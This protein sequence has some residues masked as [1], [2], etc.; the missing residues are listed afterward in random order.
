[1][2]SVKFGRSERSSQIT[3]LNS[4]QTRRIKMVI[5]RAPLLHF[6]PEMKLIISWQESSIHRLMEK[7]RNGII[8]TRRT[9]N[10][11]IILT[12]SWIGTIQ[13]ATT[14]AWM[15]NTIF[16]LQKTLFGQ[17]CQLSAS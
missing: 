15:K 2:I 13:S 6:L 16:R 17:E 11:L 14:R 7:S 10:H 4:S 1:M 8:H 5:L 12:N 9:E 3:A